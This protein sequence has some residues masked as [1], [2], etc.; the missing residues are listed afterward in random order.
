[1]I[2]STDFNRLKWLAI[3]QAA[4]T[5]S[6]WYVV[7]AGNKISVLP[8]E[9]VLFSRNTIIE[10]IGFPFSDWQQLLVRGYLLPLEE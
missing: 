7:S 5:K 9:K 1:M 3:K 8:V 2:S 6:L 4:A 10:F